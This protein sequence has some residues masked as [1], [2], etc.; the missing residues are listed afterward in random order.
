MSDEIPRSEQAV[1][2]LYD[3]MKQEGATA[4]GIMRQMRES[5]FSVKEITNAAQYM[6]D[7]NA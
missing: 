4:K 7:T 2:A 5:G 3:F 1:L 6:G